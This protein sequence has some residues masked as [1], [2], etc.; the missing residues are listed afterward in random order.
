VKETLAKYKEEI[1]PIIYT[2][3]NPKRMAYVVLDGPSGSAP[4]PKPDVTDNEAEYYAIAYGI[5][6]FIAAREGHGH[7]L[8]SQQYAQEGNE[9]ARVSTP[10]SVTPRP[11]PPIEIRSDSEVVVKQLSRQY[12][13]AADNLRKLAEGIWRQTQHIDVKFTWVPRNENLAGKMLK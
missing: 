1:M 6:Q 13:I 8:D 2:D 9:I 4:V 10:A 3:A 11:I 7:E 5:S 12:H